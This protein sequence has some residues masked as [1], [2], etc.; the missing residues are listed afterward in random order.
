MFCAL[1]LEAGEHEIELRYRTPG[2]A[3]GIVLSLIGFGSW[4]GI[5]LCCRRKK[6]FI[7]DIP[8]ESSTAN[9]MPGAV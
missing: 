3:A 5:A 8:D 6:N 7:S 2:L 1:P 9:G 4:A